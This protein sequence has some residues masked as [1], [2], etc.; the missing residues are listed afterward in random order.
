MG[1]NQF[2]FKKRASCGH[3]IFTIKTVS[4]YLLD[5]KEVGYAVFYDFSKAFDRINRT[6]MLAKLIGVLNPFLWRA[7][8]NYYDVSVII[9]KNK[10]DEN[11]F[12]IIKVSI[13]VK[14]GGPLSPRLFTGHINS[15]LRLLKNS[16]MVI[17]INGIQMGLMVY[18]DETA[19]ISR[20]PEQVKTCINII[21]SFC[22]KEDIT[23]NG[24]KSVWMKLGEKP[25]FHPISKMAVPRPPEA[26]VTFTAAGQAIEKVYAFKYLGYI[27]TSDGKLNMHIEKRKKAANMP[28][29][30]LDKMNLKSSNLLPEI[31]GLMIQALA[32]SRL[33]YGMESCQMNEDN[34]DKLETFEN[35][36]TKNTSTCP[37]DRTRIQYL[38]P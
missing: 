14:Q 8:L 27:I 24:K 22:K 18:A 25:R 32:R 34:L 36:I 5:N 26:N 23:L 31:K 16:G 19:T 10:E 6:K 29:R 15:L 21:E 20:T 28:K 7:L 12:R 17:S 11:I 4:K 38:R 30:E 2:G 13:G 33:L 9:K 3:A 35:N 1:E 37:V